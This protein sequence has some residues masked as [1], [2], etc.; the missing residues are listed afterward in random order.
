MIRTFRVWESLLIS[1]FAVIPAKLSARDPLV[2]LPFFL[3]LMGISGLYEYFGSESDKLYKPNKPIPSGRVEKNSV[4]QISFGL[5][6][7]SLILAIYYNILYPLFLIEA[8]LV[9]YAT[10]IRWGWK[11]LGELISAIAIA[12][13]P[14]AVSTHALSFAI[15][16]FLLFATLAYLLAGELAHPYTVEQNTLVQILGEKQTKR[17]ALFMLVLMAIWGFLPLIYRS[18]SYAFF[19][20][21]AFSMLSFTMYFVL[22]DRFDRA[23]KTVKA[24]LL[25]F[26][27]ACLSMLY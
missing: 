1:L 8:V 3:G 6:V 20:S 24:V 21:F 11:F 12:S 10:H 27:V 13:Y 26:L 5:L 22:I 7:T 16:W 18:T 2:F 17:V 15:F 25:L 23:R 9:F 4:L 19:F 14:L